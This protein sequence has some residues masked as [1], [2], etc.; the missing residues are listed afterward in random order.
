MEKSDL[1]SVPTSSKELFKKSR[2]S[3][4]TSEKMPGSSAEKK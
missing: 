1:V 2:V 3:E 4:L